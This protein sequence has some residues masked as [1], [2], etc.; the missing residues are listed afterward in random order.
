MR[1]FLASC[2]AEKRVSKPYFNIVKPFSSIIWGS[3]I[4]TIVLVLVVRF[5]YKYFKVENMHN[6]ESVI[7]VMGT[8]EGAYVARL[9][10][11]QEGSNPPIQCS[12][13]I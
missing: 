9:G 8:Y 1:D 2:C 7:I 10:K 5:K 4:G 11:K 13:V 6:G 12:S 3:I